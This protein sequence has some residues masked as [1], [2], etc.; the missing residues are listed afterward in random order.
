[1]CFLL[2]KLFNNLCYNKI[3]DKMKNI[4]VFLKGIFLGSAVVVPGFSGGTLAVILDLYEKIIDSVSNIRKS[5]KKHLRFLFPLVIGVIVGVL[6]LSKIVSFSLEHYKS[7]AMLLFVGLIIGG[8][9]TLFKKVSKKTISSKNILIAFGAFVLV[10]A[11]V[12]FKGTASPKVLI[13]LNTFDYLL[14]FLVGFLAAVTLVVPG[15]SGSLLLLILG[16]YEAILNSI[17]AFFSFDNFI[18]NFSILFVFGLGVLL[19]I[20]TIVKVIDYLFKKHHEETYYAIFGIIIA[21]ILILIFPLKEFYPILYLFLG[22]IITY[23]LG[24]K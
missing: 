11:F 1:M 19:G 22:I 9:P 5:P 12:L 15:I 2:P 8:L 13:N 14:L 18:L 6:L 17:Q 16:Y 21:S 3:G 10:M 20:G 4:I 7:T 24:K 23:R